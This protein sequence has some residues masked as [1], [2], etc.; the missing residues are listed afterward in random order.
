MKKNA[1]RLNESA[2]RQIVAESVKRVL[3]ED[4]RKELFYNKVNE[5]GQK[6]VHI[7]IKELQSNGVDNISIEQLYHELAH[8]VEIV[9]ENAAD[10]YEWWT[11]QYN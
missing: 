6:N 10:I 2:I 1:I 3:N 7:Q 5:I 4:N 9:S 11:E 8:M